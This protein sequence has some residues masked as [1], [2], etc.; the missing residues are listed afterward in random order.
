M[1]FINKRWVIFLFLTLFLTLF[2]LKKAAASGIAA[3]PPPAPDGAAVQVAAQISG[4]PAEQLQI[5]SSASAELKLLG[6]VVYSY[7]VLDSRNGQV[8][9]FTLDGQGH[10][11]DMNVLL[12]ADQAAYIK[13]YGRLDP[14]L[15]AWV[16]RLPK[17]QPVSVIIWLKMPDFQP[18]DKTE[19]L[20]GSQSQSMLQPDDAAA[21]ASVT[22]AAQVA[23]VTA[24]V[25]ARLRSQGFNL[26]SDPSAP[27]L[28]GELPV[29]MIKQ[30][31]SW[32]EVD[33]VYQD[34]SAK[35]LLEIAVPTIFGDV[36]QG[37]GING[38]GV[39]LAQVEVGGRIS[40][41]NPYLQGIFQD[42]T[43][44]CLTDDF[45]STAVAGIIHST[46]ATRRGVAYGASLWAGGACDSKSSNIQN[47]VNAAIGWGARVV[48]LSLGVD[49]N[50]ALGVLDRFLDTQVVTKFSTIVVAA[51]NE[52]YPCAYSSSV[53]SPALAYNVI[54]VGNFDDRRTTNL[55]DDVM[56]G[57]SSFADPFSTHGDREKPE[58]VAPGTNIN[59][60]LLKT[61]FTGPVGS[62]TSFSAPMVTGAAGLL[63]QRNPFLKMWPEAIKSIMMT[64]ALHNLEGETRLSEKDGAGGIY[65][66]WA[67][68]VASGAAGAWGAQTYNCSQP[69]YYNLSTVLLA[70]GQRL[71]ATVVWDNNPT[72][73]F[74]SRQPGTDLDLRLLAP[75]GVTVVA[76]SNSWDNTYEIIDYNAASNGNYSLQVF[77]ARCDVYPPYLG[78]SWFVVPPGVR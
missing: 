25:A 24:P 21:N 73:T 18:V 60:T 6:Q 35:S 23:T 39:K 47:R 15:A 14:G 3:P 52:G 77:R 62:G 41:T 72:Y 58:V 9:T 43:L 59:S 28:F 16:S 32:P 31:G 8:T 49:T 71:R 1:T 76:S 13:T 29:W 69:M 48:N 67:D 51:G 27:V 68:D 20:G 36:V 30:V 11:V 10:P 5:L 65:T 63:M 19:V 17:V 26:R 54:S 46:D 61:P 38:S 78:W 44:T 53:L 37:R 66:D 42:T 33:T 55:S 75:D 22:Y 34:R 7:K 56:N 50:L 57:C 4:A 2:G 64:T 12:A 40:K 45:H 74:W 70:A